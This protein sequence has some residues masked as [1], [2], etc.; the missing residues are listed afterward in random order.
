MT[1]RREII[2]AIGAIPVAAAIGWPQTPGANIHDRLGAFMDA[3]AT[4]REARAASREARPRILAAVRT[5]T[6]AASFDA[7]EIKARAR[8]RRIAQGLA[9]ELFMPPATSDAEA[10][11]QESVL[12]IYMAELGGSSATG[13]RFPVTRRDACVR[14]ESMRASPPVR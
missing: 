10:A 3:V 4:F 5:S 1:T 14:S 6:L 12:R 11:M 13:E 9:E 8:A 2:K 7:P